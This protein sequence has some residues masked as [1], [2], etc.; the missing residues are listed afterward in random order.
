MR[1]RIHAIGAGALTHKF[2]LHGNTHGTVGFH[3]SLKH[4]LHLHQTAVIVGAVLIEHRGFLGNGIDR[5]TA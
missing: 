3:H 4:L 5:S 1:L 2:Y